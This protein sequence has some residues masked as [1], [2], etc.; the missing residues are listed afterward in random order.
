MKK[1]KTF[2]NMITTQMMMK[3]PPYKKQAVSDK[4]DLVNS[5]LLLRHRV[6]CHLVHYTPGGGGVDGDDDADNMTML[7]MMTP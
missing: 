3:S 5:E 2:E 6:L 1:M 7:T 4:A